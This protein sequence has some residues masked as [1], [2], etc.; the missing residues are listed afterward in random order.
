MTRKYVLEIAISVT[1]LYYESNAIQPARN[2]VAR[3]FLEA[4]QLLTSYI[5]II[6]PQFI[7]LSCHSMHKVEGTACNVHSN[8]PMLSR[9]ILH[10]T[11]TYPLVPGFTS[12]ICLH[13]ELP[14]IWP[15]I[16]YGTCYL[17]CSPLA[18]PETRIIKVT[19]LKCSGFQSGFL[20]SRLASDMSF[21]LIISSYNSL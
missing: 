10:M 13:P 14:D 16:C 9:Y 12:P 3:G 11:S 21:I 2:T 17:Y 1:Q 8:N 20:R 6:I 19:I 7:D 18:H 15:G 4:I 5:T